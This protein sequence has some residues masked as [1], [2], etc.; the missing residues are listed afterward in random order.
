M[1][2][3]KIGR[4]ALGMY[5]TNCYFLYDE[6]TMDALVFDPADSGAY[7]YEKLTEKGFHIGA[8]LLTHGHFDHIFGVKDLQKKAGCKI[9]AGEKEEKLLGDAKLN[10]SMS[11]GRGVEIIPDV[12]LK[13]GETLELCGITLKVIHTPG[14]TEGSIC[15]YEKEAGI[16]ISGDTLF[17]GSVGRSD[18]PT[19]SA[20]TLIQSIKEKI[21]VLP[22]NVRVYPGHGG[23]T[24]IGSEKDYN[25]FI[26]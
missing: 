10:C 3:A 23:S 8:I 19:G 16:L 22:D 15:F 4:I 5:Q 20:A 17:E 26:S 1:A 2:T 18:L 25:P 11:V 14:H 21:M 13:D 24:T 6:D 12:L 7:I 9:Y